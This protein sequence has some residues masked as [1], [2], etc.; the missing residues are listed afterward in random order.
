MEKKIILFFLVA[1][2]IGAA[3]LVLA[4]NNSRV[5]EITGDFLDISSLDLIEPKDGFLITP[6]PPSCPVDLSGEPVIIN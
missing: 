3:V 1:V 2:M 6:E 4:D 5:N